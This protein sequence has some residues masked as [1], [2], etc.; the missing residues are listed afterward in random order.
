MEQRRKPAKHRP[1]A[2]RRRGALRK[3]TAEAKV[4]AFL[5]SRTEDVRYL[6]GFTG[7][8]SFL[9]L[10]RR[11]AVLVTDGRYVE[12]ARR[13][14][15]DIEVCLRADSIAVA[16]A[17][18]AKHRK[19]KRLG[20]QAEDVTLLMRDA[21]AS[22]LGG[23]K[24]VPVEKAIEHL[25]LVKDADEI[26]AIRKAVRTAERAFGRLIARGRKGLV[27]RTERD[28]AAEL[29][30]LMRLSGASGPAFSTIVAAGAHSSLP[31]HRPGSARIRRD[32][33]VLI[34]W[35]ANVE[36]YRSDLTRVVFTGRI[37]SKL[38]EVYR[39]VH[40]AQAAGIRAIRPGIMC[41]SADEAAR[42]VITE[43]GYAER[44]VHGLGHGIGLAIHEAPALG[45]GCRKRLRAGMVVTV[46]PGI[47]LPGVGGVR[48][49]DDI[50][51][52]RHGARRMSSL[53]RALQAMVLK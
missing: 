3:A 52:T 6:S 41:K 42:K 25:R 17:K 5:V 22:K 43:A 27:G 45:G 50:L 26:K 20:V 2:S 7:D 30:Y 31:H 53:P 11:L 49:E 9:M 8:D 15:G 44:F 48:I 29:D 24:I 21:L 40:R 16:V 37:P 4:D 28:V 13:E 51:V 10:G 14:C 12:Q 35:G 38:V 32:Q 36:G 19:V 33:P 47:Y 39:V 46:E 34:D 1:H 18:L 23:G